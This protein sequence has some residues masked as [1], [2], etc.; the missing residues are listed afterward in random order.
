MAKK[1]AKSDFISTGS[2]RRCRIANSVTAGRILIM[3]S[4]KNLP[5]AW[6]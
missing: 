4:P 5:P 3:K 1:A 6:N 2:P